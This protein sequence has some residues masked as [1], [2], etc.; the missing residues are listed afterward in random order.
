M[1]SHLQAFF[2]TRAT[3]LVMIML[4][5]VLS[6]CDSPSSTSSTLTSSNSGSVHSTGPLQDQFGVA[7]TACLPV[8]QGRA[9]T[10]GDIYVERPDGSEVTFLGASLQESDGLTLVGA[11]IAPARLPLVLGGRDYPPAQVSNDV[12]KQTRP[13]EGAVLGEE[14]E[15]I[16]VGIRLDEPR[17]RAQTLLLD[18]QVDGT[19]HTATVDRLYELQP[20][21]QQ[22]VEPD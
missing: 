13:L 2:A 1:R 10:F 14:T 6:G 9:V 11:A 3:I 7:T 22:G 19:T 20:R 8:R 17:G 16:L 21:C 15:L 4:G 18:Y 5:G 12:W